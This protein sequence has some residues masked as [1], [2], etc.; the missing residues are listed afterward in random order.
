MNISLAGVDRRSTH[1]AMKSSRL[2]T[3]I[4]CFALVLSACGKHDPKSHTP[5]ETAEPLVLEVTQLASSG[6]PL[7]ESSPGTVRPYRQAEVS[8][9]LTGRVLQMLAVPGGPAKEGDLLAVIEAGDLRAAVDRVRAERDQAKLDYDRATELL[10]NNSISR[11]DHEQA[12]A[13]YQS[14][15]AATEEVASALEN[16]EVRAPFTGTITRKDMDPGDLAMPGKPLFVIEDTD[17]LRL[18]TH[19]AE[20]LAAALKTG[21]KLRVII[22]SPGLDLEGVVAEVP[23]A[24]DPGSRTFLVKIDLPR[25]DQLRSGQFGHALLP[26]GKS[27]SLD[28]PESAVIVRGQMEIAF[29]LD[30]GKA[31][32]R[33][34]R[35]GRRDGGRIEV[36]SGLIPG[37]SLIVSPGL[38]LRDGDPVQTS[39][40]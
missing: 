8:S 13:R 4:P 2:I 31:R 12:R 10:P 22:D 34:V 18:E 24:A 26:A 20:S 9:K 32:M 27:R 28:V 11:A 40:K 7:F 6:Q 36:V 37:E 3:A 39:A 30:D 21:D 15:A 23:P 5:E 38:T 14:A 1:A 16:A 19:V 17:P 29:V 35:T 25:N 33:I